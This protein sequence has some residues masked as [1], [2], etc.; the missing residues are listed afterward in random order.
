MNLL[1]IEAQQGN[2]KR[3]REIL[4]AQVPIHGE[5]DLRGFEWN[6]WYRFLNQAQVLQKFE[7]FR[8]D[9]SKSAIVPGGSYVALTARAEDKTE[10]RETASGAIVGTLPVGLSTILINRPRFSATGRS[11]HGS[12]NTMLA[13]VRLANQ[14]DSGKGTECAVYEPTGEKYTFV[15]PSGSLSHVSFLNISRDGRFVA[16]LGN[17]VSHQQDQPAARLLIWNVDT[18]ELVLNQVQSRELNRVEFS[19]D[20]TMVVAYL[21]HGTKRYSDELRD[22]AVVMDVATGE[23]RGIVRHNDD[24]D[25]VFWLP[26]QERLL[27]STLGYS[28]SNRLELLSWTIGADQPQRLSQETM[29]NYIK[30]AISPDG[31]LFAVTGHSRSSIRLIDTSGGHVV[32]TLHN[33]AT[34]IHSLTFSEDGQS[35]IACS[36]TG[37]V[38]KWGLSQ[39]ADL[40][41]L[42]AKP[43][44][45]L[46]ASGYTLSPDQSLLAVAY[47]DGG[48]AI[49]TK[50]GQETILRP[51][52]PNATSGT[53]R[54]QFSQ[55]QRY[56]A[57]QSNIGPDGRSLKRSTSSG[58][59]V[60][61][62]YLLEL[63]DL[64]AAKK[65]W[66][67]VHETPT[68]FTPAMDQSTYPMEFDVDQSRL[69]VM[70][71][72]SLKVMTCRADLTTPES[73]HPTS[74]NF[75]YSRLVRVPATG[76]I[77]LGGLEFADPPG[78]PAILAMRSG[79]AAISLVDALTHKTV[80][81]FELPLPIDRRPGPSAS[82]VRVIPS[83][84]GIHACVLSRGSIEQN[85]L[86]R[87]EVWNLQDGVQVLDTDGTAVE[88]SADGTLAAIMTEQML[89]NLVSSS[90][91]RS[92]REL[93]VWNI[94]QRRRLCRISLGGNQADQIR[95]SPDG[96][97]LLTLHGKQISGDGGAVAQGKLWDL[98][99]GRE[100]LAMPIADVNLYHWDLIF[101][102][103]GDQ[104][105]S[106]LFGKAAG[107]GSG[108]N[109]VVYDA[110][111]M[112]P[113]DDAQFVARH[114]VETLSSETPLVNEMVTE[115]D[116]RK[117]LPPLVRETAMA[118]V[119]KTGLNAD[120]VADTCR[121]ILVNRYGNETDFQKALRWT[122]ALQQ[123]E[124]DTLRTRV[125]HGAACVRCGHMEKAIEILKDRPEDS[126]DPKR[127]ETGRIIANVA[128]MLLV[129]LVQSGA[130]PQVYGPLLGQQMRLNGILYPSEFSRGTGF[131]SVLHAGRF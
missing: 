129:A 124:P 14:R 1:R 116:A 56:L 28:G 37:E 94:L 47:A 107:S 106:F 103:S 88:F 81:S 96:N 73:V 59:V 52:I 6:Y 2:L 10:I 87:A 76:Q 91:S 111:P 118:L 123:M 29:P 72:E 55:D 39:N 69:V 74:I 79:K 46:A 57:H 17:D 110:T 3:M 7:D 21:C 40:F 42:R 117:G 75:R 95:F 77:L 67:V 27:L 131:T 98:A 35:I 16:A 90:A 33:E 127:A 20:G 80:R 97:R 100:I 122:E 53:A 50:D 101:D 32:H 121:R 26:D 43:L 61:N 44:R 4:M 71:G 102:A 128:A 19:P 36:T 41:A 104:L 51:E 109:A 105:T 82:A 8:I 24:L 49:R 22:V 84:D 99:S 11:V 9:T 58:R 113:Q 130:P 89:P 108:G 15:Y 70:E 78:R 23:E 115:I 86:G 66:Q 31:R 13:Y 112:S 125:L 48:V 126:S 12:R 114:L 119:T 64:Q 62:G 83:P 54:L 38:L 68:F 5:E 45:R 18:Q 92:I 63:Y 25:D 120:R 34:T 30:G 65:L 60:K 93:T 85:A